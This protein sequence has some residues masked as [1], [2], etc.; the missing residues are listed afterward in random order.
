MQS[1]LLPAKGTMII[2]NGGLAL[3]GLGFV[4]KYALKKF[5]TKKSD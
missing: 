5:L 4:I 2:I 3:L 1:L